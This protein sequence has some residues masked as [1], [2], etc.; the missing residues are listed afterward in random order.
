MQGFTRLQWYIFIL[1]ILK[2]KSNMNVDLLNCLS[3]ATKFRANPVKYHN[4]NF[5][6]FN[7]FSISSE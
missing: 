2:R 4:N 7:K 3:E 1:S 6:K 5:F